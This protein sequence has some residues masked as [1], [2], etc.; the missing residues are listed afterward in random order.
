MCIAQLWH[1]PRKQ[2]WESPACLGRLCAVHSSS[3]KLETVLCLYDLLLA[4][5]MRCLLL[6]IM[7]R[8]KSALLPQNMAYV[9]ANMAG[10]TT[11]N[12]KGKT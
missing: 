8:L 6:L 5:G 4:A 11:S 1:Q 7:M 3:K 2:G 10:W 12:I 9:Q